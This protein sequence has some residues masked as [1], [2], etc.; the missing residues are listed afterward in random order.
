[1][2][3]LDINLCDFDGIQLAAQRASAAGLIR[4]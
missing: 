3:A 1:M 2:L 4:F